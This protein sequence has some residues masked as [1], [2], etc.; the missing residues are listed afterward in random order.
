MKKMI[1]SLT[2]G[3]AGMKSCEAYLVSDEDY[4]DW[5]TGDV[6]NNLDSE[7]WQAA[8]DFAESYG[9]YLPDEDNEEEETGRYS[10]ANISGFWEE[11]N[12]AKHDGK[13]L[14]EFRVY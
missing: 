6:N 2:T 11:Y 9:I 7:A 1:L 12:P 10:S 5:K 13:F 14:G 3:Y 8:V 4:N